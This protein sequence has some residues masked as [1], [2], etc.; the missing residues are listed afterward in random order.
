MDQK[1]LNFKNFS[2]HRGKYSTRH[3][4]WSTLYNDMRHL[5]GRILNILLLALM[6]Y[7]IG[8]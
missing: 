5:S 2:Q 3:S 4:L 7:N 1:F 6:T 8:E